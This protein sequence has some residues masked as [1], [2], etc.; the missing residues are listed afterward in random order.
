MRRART[1]RSGAG[2]AARRATTWCWAWTRAAAATA[3]GRPPAWVSPACAPAARGGAQPWGWPGW[4]AAASVVPQ[5]GLDSVAPPRPAQGRPVLPAVPRAEDALL[6]VLNRRAYVILD[7]YN[8][9]RGPVTEPLN[10]S[11]VLAGR[12]DAGGLGTAAGGPRDS[13]WDVQQQIHWA[14]RL[15]GA[16]RSCG[17]DLR[18]AAARSPAEGLPPPCPACAACRGG[19]QGG[20]SGGSAAEREPDPHWPPGELRGKTATACVSGAHG[21]GVPAGRS[22]SPALAFPLLEGLWGCSTHPYFSPAY[23][24]PVSPGFLSALAVR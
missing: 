18:H 11:A 4:P 21:A 20:G 10:V 2:W 23:P 8:H 16:C 19:R 9:K 13:A 3:R 22:A 17:H 7:S 24:P 15:Q 14:G 12:P 6:P 1:T 5:R